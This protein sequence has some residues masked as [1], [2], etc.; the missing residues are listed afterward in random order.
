MSL[1]LSIHL[2][3]P[4]LTFLVGT[5][6][7]GHV[8]ARSDAGVEVRSLT[9]AVGWRTEGDGNLATGTHEE[10]ALL[11]G[12]TTFRRGEVRRLPFSF[13]APAGPISYRGKH[14]RVTS[15]L[16]ASADI[17]WARDPAAEIGFELRPVPGQTTSFQGP[18]LDREAPPAGPVRATARVR[19]VELLVAIA[20]AFLALALASAVLGLGLPTPAVVAILVLA[21]GAA[22][23]ALA[24]PFRARIAETRL[25]RVELAVDR[26]T[27][28][29]GE[30]IR[31]ALTFEPRVDLELQHA[32]ARLRATEQVIK[33]SGKS[34]KTHRHVA[35]EVDATLAGGAPIRAGGRMA[36]W[37]PLDVPADA[38]CSFQAGDNRLD[39]QL[40]VRIAVRLWPD[41]VLVQPVR[42]VPVANQVAAGG[43]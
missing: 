3:A 14:L 9:L 27:L 23:L 15:F 5:G 17:P 41:W 29:P 13:T 1:A 4:D 22:G 28:A 6:V 31:V 38:P 16:R 10:L 30:T 24:F 43:D 32:R 21:A 33:G 35:T 19:P 20:V 39:W 34:Q 18:A 36:V 37:A 11:D 2:D 8:E 40:E 7:R 42:V 26:T 12:P 25:G